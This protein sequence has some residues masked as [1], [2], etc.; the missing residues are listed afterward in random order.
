MAP[1]AVVGFLHLTDNITSH[2]TF[3][4]KKLLISKTM[5]A[6][7]MSLCAVWTVQRKVGGGS[8]SGSP[9]QGL[10]STTSS[11]GNSGVVRLLPLR[12]TGS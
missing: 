11:E 5:L 6:T 8:Y 2:V 3:P 12:D 9:G 4:I 1:N 7:S 10:V